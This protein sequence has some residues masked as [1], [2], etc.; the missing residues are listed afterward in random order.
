MKPDRSKL[1]AGTRT[2]EILKAML[3]VLDEINDKLPEA[4]KALDKVADTLDIVSK[5]SS[6]DSKRSKK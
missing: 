4:P 6:I 1:Y 3:L 5:V 2:E